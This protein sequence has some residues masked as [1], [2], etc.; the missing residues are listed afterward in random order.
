ML[1]LFLVRRKAAS[2]TTPKTA[3]I[4]PQHH[5]TATGTFSREP[6]SVNAKRTHGELG[7]EGE[8]ADDDGVQQPQRA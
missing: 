7:A 3:S 6:P 5:L 4:P 1:S 8:L 2:A